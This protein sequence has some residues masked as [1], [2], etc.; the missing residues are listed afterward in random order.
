MPLVLIVDDDAD[1]R[2]ALSE[3]LREEGYDVAVAEDGARALEQMA[4]ATP[5]AILLD[6]MMPKLDGREFMRGLRH[7]PTE[8]PVILFTAGAEPKALA[9]ALG[10]PYYIQ[11]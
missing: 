1:I 6:V 2:D 9:E 5:D 4:K 10:T 8:V 3:T 7:R 11:K